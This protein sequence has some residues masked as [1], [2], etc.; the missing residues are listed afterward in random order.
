MPDPSTASMNGAVHWP[1]PLSLGAPFFRRGA[2]RRCDLCGG[3]GLLDDREAFSG[4]G[5][6]RVAVAGR[7]HDREIGTML[8]Q[9]RREVE[10][11]HAAG[12]DDVGEDEIEAL[13]GLDELERIAGVRG[14]GHR[15]AELLEA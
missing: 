9:P 3:E 15:V 12:H 4:A 14:G 10:P 6:D 1:P 5:L 13:P 2:H 7:K 11:A 8:A